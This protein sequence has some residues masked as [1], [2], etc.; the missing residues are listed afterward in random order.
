MRTDREAVDI[1]DVGAGT[2]KLTEHLCALQV[3]SVKAVE[4]NEEMRA[5]GTKTLPV[6]QWRKGS[7]EDTGL[8]D[9]SVDWVLMECMSPERYMGVWYSVND[10][11]VQ[12]GPQQWQ[13]VL[14]M[15]ESEIDGLTEIVVPYT[16]RSWTVVRDSG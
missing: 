5:E 6:V 16:T 12:A 2:G 1:A 15:I 10:I 13:Q 4:P 7:H 8:P 11:Q 14:A 3:R 9:Q